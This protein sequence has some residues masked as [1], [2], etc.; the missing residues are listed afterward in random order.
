MKRFSRFSCLFLIAG[1]ACGS[2]LA[3]G[4]P[5]Y[6]TVK[7]K[8]GRIVK[9]QVVE[10]RNDSL[11][12]LVKGV[13][14]TFE[15]SFVA[16]ISYGDGAGGEEGQGLAAPPAQAPSPSDLPSGAAA[17]DLVLSRRYSVP[18]SD[19]AW[20]RSQGVPDVDVAMVFFVAAAARVQPRRVVHLY[21]EGW[22]WDEIE[23]YFQI[24]TGGADEGAYAAPDAPYV[25]DGPDLWYGWDGYAGYPGWGYYGGG[26]GYGYGYGGSY[27]GGH[28]G[29]GSSYGSGRNW[30][31]GAHASS[32][33]GGHSWGG[34]SGGGAPIGTSGGGSHSGG[35]S[36]SHNS[37]GH[38]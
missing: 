4:A 37:R 19:V 31:G 32:G 3:A 2:L 27:R 21:L 16:K 24:P 11:V 10:E 17:G 26:Y 22:S 18:V 23:D 6:D 35:G 12:V 33:S 15:R 29:G 14:R 1:L 28:G 5:D 20:V 30:G 9:G 34:A 7:L 13:R 25:V 38:N 36:V 8:D